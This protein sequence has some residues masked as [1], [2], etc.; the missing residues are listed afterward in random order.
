MIVVDRFVNGPH[1]CAYLE[2]RLA[3]LAYELVAAL[4]PEEYEARMNAGWRKFGALLFHPV[5]T[6]CSLCRPIR[7]DAQAFAPNR[8]QRRVLKRNAG[9]R[10][11]V[12]D[13]QGGEDRLTLYH[14]YHAAQT[15]FKGWP[16][17]SLTPLDYDLTFVEN[18]LPSLEVA[19]FDG[20][21]LVAVALTDVTPNV[22]S[23]VY[24]YY[25]PERRD[26][27]L[28]TFALLHTLALTQ[29]L[30]KRWAYFGYHVAGSR[31]MSYKAAFRPCEILQPDGR[32]LPPGG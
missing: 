6:R 24:H 25:A 29:R 32:W 21:E 20:P 1:A 7:I 10:V 4:S 26:D 12:G 27:G 19:V 30:G 2:G 3:T 22:V 11:E 5:C 13:P 17:Q 16:E 9:L 28:G 31:S 23:G 8:S 14:R 18:P 15:A